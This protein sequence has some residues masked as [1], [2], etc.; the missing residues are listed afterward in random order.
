MK[1]TAT[2]ILFLMSFNLSIFAQTNDAKM[3]AFI[4]SLM[5][6][7]TLEEKI[8]QLNLPTIG[9]DVTGPV[10]SKDVEEKIKNGSVGGVF[11]T[12]GPAAVRKLQDMAVKGSRLKIPL[13]FGMDIIHGHTTIFPIALGLS[14]SWDMDLIERSA[15]IAAEESTA[16][17]L[18]WTF[19]P[20]VDIA[21]DPRWG[22]IAE[23]AGEDPYLGSL[24]AKAMVRGYQGKGLR[25]INS[26]MACVK[27]F[28]L[29]GAAEGGRDYNTVDMSPVK[30]YEYYLPPYKAAVEAGVA[31]VMSS[32]NEINGIPATGNKWLLTDLLRDQWG[33]RGFVVTDYTA[34]NEMQEHGMGNLEKVT[35]LAIKAG[36]D[37]DMVSEAFLTTLK[38][39][40]LQKKIT[41]P[42]I[43]MACRRILEAKYK[44]GLFDD[45]YKN[46][47]E[48]KAKDQIFTLSNRKAAR[49]IAKHSFVLLKNEHK[50]LPLKR[51]GT[52][53]VIGPLADDHRDMI[54]PQSAA[55][56]WTKSVSVMDG[57]KEVKGIQLL[58]SKGANITEDPLLVKRLN[59]DGGEIIMETRSPQQ[60]IDDAVKVAV[61]ADVII[62]VLG[63]SQGMTGEA[64]SRSD[65]DIPENQVALL[66]ALVATGKT[67]VL[68]LMNGRPL[69]LEWESRN[70]TAILETWFAGTEAGNAI[71]DVLFGDY[72]PSG[73]LTAS[74]PYNVGQIPI[75]YNHKNTGRPF[76]GDQLDKYKSRYLDAPNDPLFPFGF[77]L[78]YTSFS[79]GEISLDKVSVNTKEKLMATIR[80]TNSGDYDGEETVQL[81][82]NEPEA[83]ITQ[84]VKKLKAFQKIF[85]KK[86]ESKEV[87]FVLTVDD[88]RFY[89]SELRYVYEPGKFKLFIGGNSKDVKE[90]GFVLTK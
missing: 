21:R 89:N 73:K 77:G 63:E 64:S 84:P 2:F 74:F 1:R 14:S 19:S 17:G 12:H 48:Q 47:N 78:S 39:L 15:R 85:L 62:A 81:Y 66:K 79:Y 42:Q 9:V 5:K 50:A 6:R 24:V 87:K 57:L 18:N 58:Y 3:N 70:A 31:S 54:G 45:P 37:M 80:I 4:S 27:H 40:L 46:I 72:N 76:A 8:G 20:M 67:V 16:D 60:L 41:E 69:T 36:V 53:A 23:G 29:Y 56:N 52:I 25:N 65:I 90:A 71:A 28:G 88:L 33:F 11:N 82:I 30:M 86:G 38:K 22:R 32:F 75:Y 59:M 61:K 43:D 35:E 44:L 55:G 26:I 51:S 34:I 83:S 13:F 10:L 49:E 68:V 7:M